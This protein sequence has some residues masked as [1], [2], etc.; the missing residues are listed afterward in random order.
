MNLSGKIDYLKDALKYN[1]LKI[2]EPTMRNGFTNNP[3]GLDE[4]YDVLKTIANLLNFE[5]LKNLNDSDS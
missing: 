2:S 1:E 4:I 5:K 3:V